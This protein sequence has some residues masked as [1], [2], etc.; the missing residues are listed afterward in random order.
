MSG[1]TMSD[2]FRPMLKKNLADRLAQRIRIMIL[3]GNYTE[4]DRL[5]SIMEMARRFGVG[6]PTLREA[7]KKV[8]TM[9]VVEIRHGSGVYVTRA[10]D[11]LV[12]AAQ[13][14]VGTVT[15]K[16]LL[17]LIQTRMPLELHS[18]ANASKNATKAQLAEMRR[19]LDTASENLNDD[20]IL[21]SVNIAFHATIAQASGNTVLAQLLEVIG[22]LF[23]EEQR[24]ILDIFGSRQRDHD[25]HL[26]ILEALEKKDEA[27]ATQRMRKHL[28]GVEAAIR[29]WDP[30]DHPVGD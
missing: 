20:A 22:D 2:A 3:E 1:K 15:R 7:L 26:G 21:T 19:L 11:V 4:G 17:D 14:F 10:R 12:V 27:L 9:G 16:L 29:Q 13:D 28:E 30:E 8:E 24:L 18:V 23:K 25:E 6:H 5:P